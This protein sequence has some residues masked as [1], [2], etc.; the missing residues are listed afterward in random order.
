MAKQQ[1]FSHDVNAFN[2]PKIVIMVEDWGVVSYAYWWTLVEDLASE[3]SNTL[4]INNITFRYYSKKW[5]IDKDE[6]QRFIK[7]LIDDYE[8]LATDD[9]LEFWSE[10]LNKRIEKVSQKMDA[11]REVYS[12]MGKRSAAKR[13]ANAVKEE[14]TT[15]S[16]VANGSTQPLNDVDEPLNGCQQKKKKENKRKEI[17]ENK[18]ERKENNRTVPRTVDFYIKN[19]GQLSPLNLEKLNDLI[20]DYGDNDVLQVLTYAHSKGKASI[21]YIARVLENQAQELAVQAPLAAGS[22]YPVINAADME[23]IEDSEVEP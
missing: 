19:I 21:G 5:N 22:K 13:K 3:D 9:G 4:P 1:Y 23:D 12:E 11:R 17:K 8:L 14:N 20:D 16:T 18:E 7:S 2:D 15:V 10:S 6:V